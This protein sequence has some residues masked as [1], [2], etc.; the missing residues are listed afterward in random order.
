MEYAEILAE[1][2]R[3]AILRLLA[4]EDGSTGAETANESILYDCLDRLG[5]DAGLTRAVVR[6]DLA[7]LVG[8]DLVRTEMVETLMVATITRRGVDV[9]RGR[10]QIKGIKKPSLGVF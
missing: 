7:F 5:L 1:H 3:L 8:R 4:G 2:R 9:A 10:E 6:E